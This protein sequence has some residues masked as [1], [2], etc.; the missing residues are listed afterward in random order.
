MGKIGQII[1]VKEKKYKYTLKRVKGESEKVAGCYGCF[2]LKPRGGY[3]NQTC[4]R[5]EN[6]CNCGS[7]FKNNHTIYKLIS[8]EKILQ[9]T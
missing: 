4:Y 5:H 9:K 7:I 8:K 2:F 3:Y 6:V 1:T